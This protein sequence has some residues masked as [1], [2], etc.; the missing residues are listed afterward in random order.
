[1]ILPAVSRL[2]RA[3]ASGSCRRRLDAAPDG[4]DVVV[5]RETSSVQELE[6]LAAGAPPSDAAK[7]WWTV[8]CTGEVRFE[9]EV[10]RRI[11]RNP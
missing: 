2:S 1:M 11:L 5:D 3:A 10:I 9:P 6:A 7:P 4:L 8:A